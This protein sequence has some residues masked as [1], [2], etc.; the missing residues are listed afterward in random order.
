[1]MHIC[2]H[3]VFYKILCLKQGNTLY[4]L[5]LS[6]CIPYEFDHACFNNYIL[7]HVNVTW[8]FHILHAFHN[9]C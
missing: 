1:M 5:M 8:D 3:F 4:T 7:T 6:I 9:A 2:I